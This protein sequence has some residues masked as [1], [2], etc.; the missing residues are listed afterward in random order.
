LVAF[1][2]NKM[3]KWLLFFAIML[4]IIAFHKPILESFAKQLLK[5]N[6]ITKNS[7]AIIYIPSISSCR[8]KE[9]K[10]LYDNNYSKKIIIVNTTQ[11]DASFYYSRKKDVFYSDKY[12]I[13]NNINKDKND[14]TDIKTLTFK[15]SK[16]DAF[17]LQKEIVKYIKK[18]KFKKVIIVEA[19]YFASATQFIF[20]KLNKDKNIKIEVF[21]ILDKDT[22]NTWWK[23][24]KGLLYFFSALYSIV[25]VRTSSLVGLI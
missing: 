20:S 18:S 24:E 22:I 5:T 11:K 8:Y 25:H 2:R 10:Y 12:K 16:I 17:Y 21:S 23:K 7:D 14:I 3:K 1:K 6:S 13:L 15:A 9:I 4:S 19:P